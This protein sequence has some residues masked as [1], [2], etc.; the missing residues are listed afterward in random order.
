MSTLTILGKRLF[1][2]F[3]SRLWLRRL[4]YLPLECVDKLSGR[5]NP[6]VPPRGLWFIGGGKRYP[7]INEETLGYLVA[8]GLQPSHS[9]LDMGC[10]IG[11]MGARLTSFLGTGSYHGFDVIRVGIKWATDNITA[12][13][14][15]FQFSHCDIYSKHYNPSGK[16]SPETFTFPYP[17]QQFD[18]AFGLS[19]FTHLLPAT[20]ERYLREMARVLKPSGI[21]WVTLF[22]LNDESELLI[23]QGKSTLHLSPAGNCWLLDQKFPETAVGLPE[24]DFR[25][26]CAGAGLEIQQVNYGSWCGRERFLTEHDTVVLRPV[27]SIS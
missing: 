12:R 22:L 9:V 16:I 14:P 23:K 2:D 20:A 17:D 1:P 27:E 10:G 21:A 26:W 18:F 15:Q 11:F 25:K 8:A 6:L 13:Y 3:N 4:A 19:L 24:Q 5:V 7:E